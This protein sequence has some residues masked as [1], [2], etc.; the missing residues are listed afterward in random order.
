METGAENCWMFTQMIPTQFLVPKNKNCNY[1]MASLSNNEQLYIWLVYMLMRGLWCG[2]GKK[3]RRNAVKIGK[4]RRFSVD[5]D[6]HE[7]TRLIV[8]HQITKLAPLLRRPTLLCT[9]IAP[10]GSRFYE[11]ASL[12]TYSQL[13]LPKIKVAAKK[14]QGRLPRASTSV[15][16]VEEA[17]QVHAKVFRLLC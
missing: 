10:T 11:M 9:Q 3:R 7:E 12:P 16:N 14:V 8:Q 2:G 15:L 13:S 4:F 17:Q 5:V 6:L 1:F